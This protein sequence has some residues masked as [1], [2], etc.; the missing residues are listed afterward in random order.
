M[1]HIDANLGQAGVGMCRSLDK[2]PTKYQIKGHL[3]KTLWAKSNSKHSPNESQIGSIRTIQED[4]L[5][6]KRVPHTLLPKYVPPSDQS[7]LSPT[8]TKFSPAR[9]QTVEKK[10]EMVKNIRTPKMKSPTEV[11]LHPHPHYARSYAGENPPNHS[12]YGVQSFEERRECCSLQNGLWS[13]LPTW[14]GWN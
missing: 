12:I 2:R 11:I 7:P 9:V 3:P 8:I 4:W 6:W 13:P 14:L 5:E 10:H 1:E